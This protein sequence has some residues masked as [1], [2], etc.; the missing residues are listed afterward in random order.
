PDKL[1]ELLSRL[2]GGRPDPAPPAAS[3]PACP[4]CRQPMRLARVT[5]VRGPT[6]LHTFECKLCGVAR[7]TIISE[8]SARAS[9][10]PRPAG[11]RCGPLFFHHL[12]W[13]ECLLCVGRDR[14]RRRAGKTA[15][16]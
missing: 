5:R 6:D 13:C 12:R 3:G 4:T 10:R 9:S 16:P 14:L 8:A 2:D 15:C 11:G 1:A 7:T